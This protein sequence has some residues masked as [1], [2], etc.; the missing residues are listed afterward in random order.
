MRGDGC[1]AGPRESVDRVL[2]GPTSYWLTPEITA[3]EARR[4]LE[5]WGLALTD[6]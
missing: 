5:N 1:Q 6:R 3:R 2:S 4:R